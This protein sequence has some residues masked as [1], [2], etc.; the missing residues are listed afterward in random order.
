MG[1]SDRSNSINGNMVIIEVI[2]L[3]WFSFLKQVFVSPSFSQIRIPSI[4]V[5]FKRQDLNL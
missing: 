1:F 5:A 2:F 4:E 3:D